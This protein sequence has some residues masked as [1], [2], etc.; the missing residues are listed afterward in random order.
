MKNKTMEQIVREVWD[1]QEIEQ[2]MYRHARSLDRM[3]GELMKSCYWEDA[4]EEHQDPIYPEL[5]HWNDNALKFVPEAMKGFTALKATQH[6]ISNILIELDGDKA[7][8]E[9]YVWAYHVGEENGVD[10]EGILGG[11]HYFDLEKRDNEWRIKYRLTIF[12]WNQNKDASAIWSDNFSEKY[13]AKR[14]YTEAS[15]N[16]I[17]K[18]KKK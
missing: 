9:T 6:R 5:F 18:H 8:A 15:Y 2:L 4:I 12:D 7:T 17:E 10:K 13:R 1:R 3:D 14:D 11:R 16:F